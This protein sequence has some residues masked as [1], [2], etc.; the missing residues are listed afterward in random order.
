MRH[1]F[2]PAAVQAASSRR[3]VR[4]SLGP[5]DDG[6][7]HGQNCRPPFGP[8]A[9]DRFAFGNEGSLKR[10]VH[11]GRSGANLKHRARDATEKA[12]LR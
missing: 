11:R 12:D 3:A 6:C 1:G 5:T 8:A 9:V 4:A 10:H 7:R 2:S